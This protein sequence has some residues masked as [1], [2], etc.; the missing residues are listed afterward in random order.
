M[1]EYE[2]EMMLDKMENVC[3]IVVPNTY[4][5]IYFFVIKYIYKYCLSYM[6]LILEWVVVGLI[7]G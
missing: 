1:C 3:T 6:P 4:C 5:F 2:S 7:Y